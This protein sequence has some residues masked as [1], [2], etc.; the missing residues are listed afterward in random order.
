M[1]EKD[2]IDLQLDSAL[3]T[4]ADPGPHSGL[5]DRV[6]AALRAV[7]AGENSPTPRR[8]RWLPWAIAVPVAACLLLLWFST[9][10]MR[11]LPWSQQQQVRETRPAPIP[12]GTGPSTAVR[13]HTSARVKRPIHMAQAPSAVEISKAIPRPKLDVF[14][15]PQPLTAEERALVQVVT[16][17]PLP[18][19]EALVEAQSLDASPVRIAEIQIPPLEPPAQGQP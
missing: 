12:S 19:R 4:Y 3:S 17:T 9:L 7:R 6:A 16:Q 1:H 18:A 2:E 14:P 8:W 5:E 10:K 15:T 13:T 11:Q